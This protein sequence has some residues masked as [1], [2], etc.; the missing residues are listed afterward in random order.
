ML[1]EIGPAWRPSSLEPSGLVQT[2]PVPVW[3]WGWLE[4][5]NFSSD[6]ALT[7]GCLWQV[8]AM[9]GLRLLDLGLEAGLVRSRRVPV[10]VWGWLE[11]YSFLQ[12]VP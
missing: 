7:G 3:V 11:A 5:S 6:G 4:A 2:R 8:G 1:I 9:S 12:M 10:W